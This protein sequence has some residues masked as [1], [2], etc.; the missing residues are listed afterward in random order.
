MQ[1]EW[2][3]LFRMLARIL[4]DGVHI[5]PLEAPG[6]APVREPFA[7]GIYLDHAAA[8]DARAYTCAEA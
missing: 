6:E 3:V 2:A 5:D 4:T 7:R 8:V 1:T